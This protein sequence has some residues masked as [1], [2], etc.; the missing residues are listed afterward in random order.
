MDGK[1]TV[2]V[3]KGQL[4]AEGVSDPSSKISQST[5]RVFFCACSQQV[6]AN[7]TSYTS[8]FAKIEF[9]NKRSDYHG[10]G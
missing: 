8:F 1:A 7:E 10:P 4:R 2:V 9:T 5:R 6:L 3:V